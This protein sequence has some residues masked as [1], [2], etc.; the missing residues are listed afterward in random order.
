[1]THNAEPEAVDLLMEVEKLDKII[2][3][4]DKE[5][6]NR[7][8][9]Y[10]SSCANYVPEP[11]DTIILKTTLEIYRKFKQWPNALRLAMRMNDKELINEVFTS[12]TDR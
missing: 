6:F 11:E 4:C 9:L 7:V 2:P 1:M 3:H 10:L 5:N 8:C 12:C